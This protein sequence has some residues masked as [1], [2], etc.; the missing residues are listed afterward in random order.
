MLTRVT[1]LLLLIPDHD[2]RTAVKRLERFSQTKSFSSKQ[3]QDR[4][5]D[6]TVV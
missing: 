4:A 2:K 3:G 1:L 6:G 5:G